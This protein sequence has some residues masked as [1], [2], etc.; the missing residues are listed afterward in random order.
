MRLVKRKFG[1]ARLA[2][3]IGIVILLSPILPTTLQAAAQESLPADVPPPL[4]TTYLQLDHHP[5]SQLPPVDTA[6]IHTRQK[7]IA[8]EA[9]FFGYDLGA[10]EWDFDE[11]SCPAIPD[12]LILHYRKPYRNG[13]QS[14]FTALVPR[15]TGRVY[16]VPVLYRNATPFFSATSSERS[17]AVFNRVVPADIAAKAIDPAGKWLSLGLCYAD[18]VYGNA[19]V[20][21]QPGTEIG[22]AR[23]PIPLL[24]L[25]ESNNARGIV[26]TDRNAPGQYLVF[27]LT[28]NEKGRILAAS[29]LQLSDYVARVRTGAEPKEKQL[30]PGQEPRIRTVPPGQ[31]P[32][33]KT[34]PQ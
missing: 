17:I 29:V 4:R 20:L 24:R 30:P 8:S 16:V 26:F 19:N 12:E 1:G 13:A 21:E 6:L 14:L 31:E 28:L 3:I 32:T 11:T 23:A 10:G 9:A 22:L 33:V 18:I 15:E 2:T 27:N 7:E 34:T 5:S 25:S